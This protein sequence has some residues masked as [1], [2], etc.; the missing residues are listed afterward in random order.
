MLEVLQRRFKRVL[1]E[2]EGYCPIHYWLMEEK[3]KSTERLKQYDLKIR[4]IK[5]LGIS[6]GI[7]RKDGLER[8]VSINEQGQF[9]ELNFSDD[10][11]F[12]LQYIRDEAHRFAVDAQ[13]R[14]RSKNKTKSRLDSIEGIGNKRQSR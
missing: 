9:K 2:R 5:I 4:S 1:T 13:R 8:F 7:S 12:I 11:K 3:V 14:S 10:T 6:K